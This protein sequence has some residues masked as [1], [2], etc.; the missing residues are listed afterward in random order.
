MASDLQEEILMAVLA[1]L[2]DRSA[3]EVMVEVLERLCERCQHTN[4]WNQRKT[5]LIILARLRKIPFSELIN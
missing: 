4:E 5:Q 3:G 1:N 2:K